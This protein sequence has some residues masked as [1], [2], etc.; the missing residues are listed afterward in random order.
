MPT[1][2]VNGTDYPVEADP[3]MPL[4]WVL[5]DALGLTGTKY[6]CGVGICGSCVV[7]LDGRAVRACAVTLSSVEGREVTTIEA[8]AA[9]K[10]H[11]LQ[12]AWI[13]EQVAQ[14]GYCVPGQIMAA[15]A[16]LA[17]NPS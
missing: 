4:L 11:A 17:S 8:L 7:H 1:I 13:V 16:L 5:R 10:Y 14:C 2:R 6:G 12:E 9:E 3:N 15:A